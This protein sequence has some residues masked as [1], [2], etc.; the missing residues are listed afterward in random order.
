[1]TAK[2][3]VATRWVGSQTGT[4]YYGLFDPE[5]PTDAQR[6]AYETKKHGAVSA[7]VEV[8]FAPATSAQLN[9]PARTEIEAERDRLAR[10]L[11]NAKGL[12][13]MMLETAT[14]A[15]DGDDVQRYCAL[16]DICNA[17]P[18]LLARIDALNSPQVNVF[19]L[20]REARALLNNEI[21]TVPD[22]YSR[23]VERIDAALPQQQQP[24]GEAA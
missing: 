7:R 14:S 1:M 11:S 12:I 15:R 23:L 22:Q 17:A 8:D 13:S 3:L 21:G 4:V 9:V 5:Q 10:A 2:S 19:D 18:P 24:N 16:D 20:L 6:L